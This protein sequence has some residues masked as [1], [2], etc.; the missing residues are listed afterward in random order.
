M[1]TL[2]AGE[3][4]F[5]TDTREFY[6]GT[7]SGNVN[8]G[9]SQWYTGTDMAGTSTT[10]T[11][12]YGSCPQVKVG[13]MYLNTSNGNTYQCTS[14]GSG[15]TAK[16]TYK[17]CIKGAKGEDGSDATVTVD[18]SM[19]AL[20]TNPVQNKVIFRELC[21]WKAWFV[22]LLATS[23]TGI[24]TAIMN[25]LKE[26]INPS[27]F[28]PDGVVTNFVMYLGDSLIDGNDGYYSPYTVRYI[29]YH[30]DGKGNNS[31]CDKI[32]DADGS[33][34]KPYSADGTTAVDVT[35]DCLI[36][37]ERPSENG[38]TLAKAYVLYQW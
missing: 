16:W 22:R 30:M 28:L 4:S 24:K 26:T 18:S 8:M 12:S 13:D 31:L 38:T 36:A 35:S 2:S 1:P 21:F 27:Y 9:G 5:T 29:K 34:W 3:P 6:I 20:S 15:A 33:A 10:T 25:E 19:K 37:F 14:A 23:G 32:V 7:G 17:G 11:Y